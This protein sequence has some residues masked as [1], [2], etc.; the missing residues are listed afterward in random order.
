MVAPGREQ[1]AEFHGWG[2]SASLAGVAGPIPPLR[3]GEPLPVARTRTPT[4]TRPANATRATRALRRVRRSCTAHIW[5]PEA[6]REGPG[7]LRVTSAGRGKPLRLPDIGQR[8][9]ERRPRP[10]RRLDPGAAPPV[11]CQ[12]DAGVQVEQRGPRTR[13][14]RVPP[15]AGPC[16]D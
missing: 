14:G 9:T 4:T 2:W 15:A 8:P 3:V 7:R 11:T 12:T 6:D 1:P 16:P 5:T 10:P 13:G